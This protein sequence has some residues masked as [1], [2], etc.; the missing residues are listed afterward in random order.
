MLVLKDSDKALEY[1]RAS[2]KE[3]WQEDAGSLNAFAWWCYE[4]NVNLKEAQA[5]AQKGA[6]LAEPGSEK[7][8]ILDTVAEI[9]NARDDCAEALAFIQQAIQEDP[10]SEYYKKQEKRFQELLAQ[11]NGN[12]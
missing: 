10:D 2:M 7:A 5:M 9:C 4:N 11:K 6:D 3:D 1:K 12:H 8:Q